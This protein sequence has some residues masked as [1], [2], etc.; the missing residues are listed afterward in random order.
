M[1]I[2]HQV[3]TA[4]TDLLGWDERKALPFLDTL[5]EDECE[6]I[7][8]HVRESSTPIVGVAA[9]V[10]SV[11]IRQA[12][13]NNAARQHAGEEANEHYKLIGLKSGSQVNASLM[14]DEQPKRVHRIAPRA[15]ARRREFDNW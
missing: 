14:P 6:D 9:V 3:K 10:Y 12:G 4:L 8:E 7:V 11:R 15:A 1:D 2:R 5:T 13:S